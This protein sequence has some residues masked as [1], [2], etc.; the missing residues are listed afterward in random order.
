MIL[1]CILESDEIALS[2]SLIKFCVSFPL[3]PFST[4]VVPRFFFS[5]A[6]PLAIAVL[7]PL[8]AFRAGRIFFRL[9]H[10]SAK[11]SFSFSPRTYSIEKARILRRGFS[12]FPLLRSPLE[13]PW[14]LTFNELSLIGHCCG[15]GSTS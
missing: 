2:Q 5:R 4:A 9:S 13:L 3:P 15:T 10:A 11:F 12:F 1:L 14:K 8:F 6:H 7:F